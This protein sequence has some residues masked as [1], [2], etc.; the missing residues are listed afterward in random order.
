MGTWRRCSAPR[1][2]L[3]QAAR[4]WQ[5]VGAGCCPRGVPCCWRTGVTPAPGIWKLGGL[6]LNLREDLL[7]TLLWLERGSPEQAARGTVRFLTYAVPCSTFPGPDRD[8]FPP[9]SLVVILKFEE[10]WRQ[11][12]LYYGGFFD[13]TCVGASSLCPWRSCIILGRNLVSVSCVLNE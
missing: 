12:M 13:D 3:P 6:W 10:V 8:S 4:C 5:R 7:I 1:R 9:L 2:V 11:T